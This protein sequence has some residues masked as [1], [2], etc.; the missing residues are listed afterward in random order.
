MVFQ[1]SVPIITSISKN[2]QRQFIQTT[3]TKKFQLTA[4]Q[5]FDKTKV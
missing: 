3:F 5:I 4:Q 1:E 2:M